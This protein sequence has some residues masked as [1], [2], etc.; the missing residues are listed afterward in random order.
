MKRVMSARI[1]RPAPPL[2][3]DSRRRAKTMI[4]ATAFRTGNYQLWK[5]M[6]SQRGD[7]L[8]KLGR[9]R[10]SAAAFPLN[11]KPDDPMAKRISKLATSLKHL[12]E[13]QVTDWDF[14][15]LLN[16]DVKDL[17][18]ARSLRR[19]GAIQVM[20]WDFRTVL[21][22][23]NRLAHREV[24]L[25]D[26]VRRTASY[27]VMEW[28]FRSAASPDAKTASALNKEEIQALIVQLKNF[29]QFVAVNLI[30]EPAHA[31]IRVQEIETNVLR[32]KLVLTKRDTATLIGT[33]GHT[34]AAIRDILKAAA[35]ARGVQVLLRIVSHEEDAETS[36]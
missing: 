11:A 2:K 33:G 9:F 31:Q 24:D 3:P 12:G 29:L 23:V 30:D 4:C 36:S 20:E 34:A 15:D 18:L 28:D 21:P 14:M 7:W 35:G 5:F 19:L 22:A 6:L 10:Q 16:K 1:V 25:V 26:I 13:I 8:V 32:V 17:E 27:K